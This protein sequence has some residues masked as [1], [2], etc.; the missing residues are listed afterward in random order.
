MKFSKRG[1]TRKSEHTALD[2]VEESFHLLRTAPIGIL[3]SYLIGSL[4]FILGLLY[5]WA[6]MASDAFA[7]RR[8][9]EASLGIAA[10][11]IW[12]KAWHAVYASRLMAQLSRR[13]PP[14]WSAA[15][16]I[17][18]AVFQGIIQPTGLIALPLAGM[19][20]LPAGWV[21]AF[22]QSFSL[23]GNGEDSDLNAAVR[24]TARLS[25]LW[26]GQN[27]L[28]LLFLSLFGLFVFLNFLICA[29]MLPEL[30]KM[31]SGIE[32]VFTKTSIFNTTL[33]AI[34]L[35]ASWL[36]VDPLV[37]AVYVLR[38]FYGESRHSGA[39]LRADLQA[40][41]PASAGAW[42]ALA[43][44]CL[45]AP[46]GIA[47]ES[48]AGPAPA[49]DS[50]ELDESI[51]RTIRK[52]EYSWR[53]PREKAPSY[54]EKGIIE[55]FIDDMI[56]TL[57]SWI[58]T[59]GDWLEKI[60]DWFRGLFPD[61]KPSPDKPSEGSRWDWALSSQV[62]ISALLAIAVAIGAIF[63]IR[64][65]RI[66]KLRTVKASSRAV[67]T[68][69]DLSDESITASDLPFD[70]WTEMANDLLSR[71]EYRLALRALYMAGLSNLAGRELVTIARFK[72]N[73]EY[74]RE[75]ARKA[76]AQQ[77]L[78]DAFSQNTLLFE[79]S[80]YGRHEATR[81]TVDEFAV[82]QNRIVTHS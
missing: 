33:F 38:C 2:L 32:S 31:L 12:M 74:Q 8:V 75:L 70:R 28:A 39:D 59:I 61:R 36:C 11:F 23:T 37:K 52:N 47:A 56:E 35:G 18:M 76:R 80:W 9:L 22:Y 7:H 60:G 21:Y 77:E 34:V 49:V 78:L 54:E 19:M 51:G 20:V 71:G 62:L 66:R 55:V 17:R 82:N 6:D 81:Q 15:A 25:S 46:A 29:A 30:V 26:P 72:S 1:R 65:W 64:M 73:R 53:L 16:A 42:I 67:Q 68:V 50:R 27:H 48:A 10:L 63:L 58:R 45:F 5:F 4:P 44:L 69:P 40:V 43:M 41:A 13:P 57:K 14:R 3:G 79:R 24:R